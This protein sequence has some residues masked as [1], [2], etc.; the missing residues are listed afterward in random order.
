M[1]AA[2]ISF[3]QMERR[4]GWVSFPGLLRYYALM[5][6]LVFVVQWI[7]PDI[8]PLLAFDRSAILSGEVWRLATCFFANSQV[9][10]PGP[11]SLIFLA[12]AVNFAFMVSDGLEGA[13][14][15]FKTSVFYYLGIVMI[16]VA[17]FLYQSPI[18]G[19]GFALYGAAFLAFAMLFPKVEILLFF[20]LPVKIGLLGI[21]A[22]AGI[23]LMLMGSPSL[24]PFFVLTFANFIVWAGI[25]ALRGRA[26]VVASGRRNRHLKADSEPETG[27]FHSCATCHCTDL[28]DPGMEFRV[29]RDDREYCI[30]HLQE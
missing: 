24:L 20:I 10:R 8:G 30:E 1:L 15:V 9:G 11:A 14:G 23:V 16:W 4:W 6:V 28:T 18:P 12:C 22:A 29:G 25:P 13:W 3:G 5:H 26:Q 19:S 2:M 27:A 7:R 21:V 17:S